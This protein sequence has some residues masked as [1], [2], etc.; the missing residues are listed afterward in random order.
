[1][2]LVSYV[3]S[4][5][6]CF[7]FYFLSNFCIVFITLKL[8][9]LLMHADYVNRGLS[10]FLLRI[11]FSAEA[12]K[13]RTVAIDWLKHVIFLLVDFVCSHHL[14]LSSA[15]YTMIGIDIS[16][17]S[18]IMISVKSIS[19]VHLFLLLVRIGLAAKNVA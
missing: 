15:V 14:I 4:I 2:G 7:A 12:L 16:V 5:P 10:R 18:T 8:P 3:I 6:A 11:G 13:S 9:Y 1:M 19:I 17:I